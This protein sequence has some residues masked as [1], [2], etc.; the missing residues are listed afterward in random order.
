MCLE[1]KNKIVKIAKDKLVSKFCNN[2]NSIEYK[3]GILMPKK[4]IRLVILIMLITMTMSNMAYAQVPNKAQ[5][6]GPKISE[7]QNKEDILNSLEQINT[8]RGNLTVID[9]RPTTPVEEL[10]TID[11]NLQRYIDQ[12]RSIRA[13]LVQH[14]DT[15]ANSISDVFFAEQIV[16]ITDCY[17][18]SLK[19]QQLLLRSIENNQEESSKLF[20]S[21]YMIPIYYYITQGDQLVAYTQTY[22]VIS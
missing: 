9:V 13:N 7:L 10:K 8:I 14:A 22:V 4:V 20:Y 12:L 15:Y 17:I 1:S 3:G 2:I 21:T 5:P 11:T 16:A 19:H 6:Y 18:I